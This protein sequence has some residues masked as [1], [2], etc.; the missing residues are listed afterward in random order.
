MTSPNTEVKFQLPQTIIQTDTGEDPR[1]PVDASVE[2]ADIK[3]AAING[4]Q[5]I[6][7]DT[8]LDN[9]VD[10]QSPSARFYFA[11]SS[12][13]VE[14]SFPIT[15]PKTKIVAPKLDDLT[16][17]TI[18]VSTGLKPNDKPKVNVN[19]A[20][21]RYIATSLSSAAPIIQVQT[22][23]RISKDTDHQEIAAR[24]TGL[25]LKNHLDELNQL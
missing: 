21:S 14:V 2:L 22:G 20:V 24:L 16:P 11:Y 9:A 23:F 10:L 5:E 15:D 3:A 19:S 18:V 7:Q 13:I 25:E 17:Q 1:T 6:L 8:G 12:T 4:A